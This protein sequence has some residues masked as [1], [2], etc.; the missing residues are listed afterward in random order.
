[1][2]LKKIKPFKILYVGN[3]SEFQLNL[4][5]YITHNYD[6]G[7]PYETKSILPHK[8]TVKE[9]C[10]YRPDAIFY[11]VGNN[12]PRI[13]AS[14]KNLNEYLYPKECVSI[15]LFDELDKET[16]ECLKFVNPNLSFKAT[17][18]G[19]EIKF[20]STALV[21]LL[22]P[23]YPHA[24]KFAIAKPEQYCDIKVPVYLRDLSANQFSLESSFKIIT[25]KLSHIENPFIKSMVID[26]QNIKYIGTNKSTDYLLNNYTT[27]F[28]VQFI[29]DKEKNKL[30]ESIEFAL[31]E[32]KELSIEQKEKA[33]NKILLK[34]IADII[35]DKKH[36]LFNWYKKH[37]YNRRGP[38]KEN[39]VIISKRMSDLNLKSTFAQKFNYIIFETLNLKNL[40]KIE[41]LNP[42][43]IIWDMEIPREEVNTNGILEDKIVDIT[44]EKNYFK[45]LKQLKEVFGLQNL[46]EK[47]KLVIF[48]P[49]SFINP[50]LIINEIGG[51]KV[52]V[53]QA[54][55]SEKNME[56]FMNIVEKDSKKENTTSNTSKEKDNADNINIHFPVGDSLSESWITLSAKIEFLTESEIVIA[57]S[58][59]LPLMT[60]L[61][62]NFDIPIVF[63]LIPNKKL[64]MQN[65]RASIKRYHGLIH[66]MTEEERKDLRSYV[67]RHE[68]QSKRVA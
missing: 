22:K 54:E 39:I 11:E 41:T 63:S 7:F 12:E 64:E 21:T 68:K 62:A 50:S 43:F 18:R 36:M 47:N 27:F 3:K 52:E 48:S 13:K 59:E 29:S 55:L 17:T 16:K 31:N 56:S 44:Y 9:I 4:F 58:S 61:R 15:G 40:K 32:K 67:I 5:G 53:I 26:N 66:C 49:D 46:S 20:I 42:S 60:T 2:S 19:E 35:S 45:S 23:D 24:K 33:L 30:K 28:D 34:K 1:M 65:A 51:L 6:K 38:A 10:Q 14:L 57:S 8:I 37:P 25:N